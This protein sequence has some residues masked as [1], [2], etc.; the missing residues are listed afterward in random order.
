MISSRLL[1]TLS[2]LK[3]L[4]LLVAIPPT[5]PATLPAFR[6]DAAPRLGADKNQ[7]FKDHVAPVSGLPSG[8]FSNCP[9][10]SQRLPF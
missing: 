4:Y 7:T 9:P 1:K 2:V 8:S 5:S 10:L 6:P 3:D